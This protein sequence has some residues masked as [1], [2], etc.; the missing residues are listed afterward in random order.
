MHHEIPGQVEAGYNLYRCVLLHRYPADVGADLPDNPIDGKNVWNL[1]VGEPG[2]ENPHDY[3]PFSTWANLEGVI[4][5][6]GRWKLH[7]PHE[8][9]TLKEAGMDGQA[10]KYIRKRIEL[11]LFDMENDPFETTNV[12]EQH[13]EV[14]AKLKAYAERH[15]E[16]FYTKRRN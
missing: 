10:G 13:P 15:R 3:Y 16:K 9:G 4:S 6:D 7:L 12:L 2:A 1:I 11:S 14:A 8:Y 5:G